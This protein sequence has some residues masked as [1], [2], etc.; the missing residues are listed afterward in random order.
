M[1][2]S[3]LVSKSSNDVIF[4]ITC[5]PNVSR[6]SKGGRPSQGNKQILGTSGLKGYSDILVKCQSL[7]SGLPN[8]VVNFGKLLK[9]LTKGK[10]PP[11]CNFLCE[12]DKDLCAIHTLKPYLISSQE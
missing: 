7:Q 10:K 4:T 2:N 11:K 1:T 5:N 3:T 9:T 8:S 6:R 12:K